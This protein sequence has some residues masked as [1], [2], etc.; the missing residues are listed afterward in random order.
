MKPIN[1]LI[2]WLGLSTAWAATHKPQAFLDSIAGSKTEG[3]AIVQHYCATCH[4]VHPL[5]PL[6]APRIGYASDWAE[7]LKQ[8]PSV[9]FQHSSEGYNAMPARG[10][11]FECSDE[12]LKLA[13][14]VLINSV[15]APTHGD[16]TGAE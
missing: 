14:A 15:S 7:R 2:F 13:I 4:A 5:I 8:G 6:G 1:L 3:Q 10:G 12:Q 9:L 16:S 11:C